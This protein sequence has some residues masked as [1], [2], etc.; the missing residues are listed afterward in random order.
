MSFLIKCCFYLHVWA[1]IQQIQIRGKRIGVWLC[2]KA[3]PL[4]VLH[5]HSSGVECAPSPHEGTVAKDALNS[6]RKQRLQGRE[7]ISGGSKELLHVDSLLF[8]F[9][10]QRFG[11]KIHHFWL[12]TNRAGVGLW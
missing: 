2:R 5:V 1:V 3:L 9:G 11:K 7:E 12:Q 10:F 4:C 6:L 8:R